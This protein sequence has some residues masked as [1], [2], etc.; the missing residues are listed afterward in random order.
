MPTSITIEDVPDSVRDELAAR[1]SRKGLTLE[2]Y[3]RGELDTLADKPDMESLLARIAERKEI[4]QTTL[5][6]ED[7][8]AYRDQGRR[9]AS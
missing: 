3:L 1:A 2:E 4:C 6:K 8:L 7:I 9:S 5:S